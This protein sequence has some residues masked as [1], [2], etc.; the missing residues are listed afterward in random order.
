M[1]EPR[2]LA[3]RRQLDL[4][5]PPVNSLSPIQWQQD[6]I[7][8]NFV[9]QASDPIT[10]ASIVAGSSVSRG[11][12]GFA[13]SQLFPLVRNSQLLQTFLKIGTQGTALTAEA[14]T[15]VISDKSA[16]VA[17]QGA[18]PSTLAWE[19][20]QGLKNSW[21]SAIVNFGSF[22]AVSPFTQGQNAVLR[23]FSNSTAIVGA[24]QITGHWGIT[25]L[26]HEN[27]ISQFV[28][29]SVM[30]LQIQA[31]MH[32]LHGMAPAFAIPSPFHHKLWEKTPVDLS[33]TLF[34]R[35]TASLELLALH[36]QTSGPLDRLS[37]GFIRTRQERNAPDGWTWLR[38]KTAFFFLSAKGKSE[39]ALE[40]T[41]YLARMD[42]SDRNAEF[43]LKAFQLTLGE[44]TGEHTAQIVG[45]AKRAYQNSS[46]P[47]YQARW[48][49]ALNML[50]PRLQGAPRLE[51]VH[52]MLEAALSPY[53]NIADLAENGLL[54]A[55]EKLSREE[56]MTA[57]HHLARLDYQE[58]RAGKRFRS[59]LAA[60][61]MGIHSQ[62][63]PASLPQRIEMADWFGQ[64]IGHWDFNLST[65]AAQNWLELLR[66]LPPAQASS[67]I[68]RHKNN[69]TGNLSAH[70]HGLE[71]SLTQLKR[72]HLWETEKY[73][74]EQRA[75]FSFKALQ[76]TLSHLPL[77]KVWRDLKTRT[78]NLRSPSEVEAWRKDFQDRLRSNDASTKAEVEAWWKQLQPEE[79]WTSLELLI[80][81]K[82]FLELQ[83]NEALHWRKLASMGLPYE[84]GFASPKSRFS[85]S[86]PV[87]MTL[88]RE[89][90]MLPEAYVD[91]IG[92]EAAQNYLFVHHTHPQRRHGNDIN[93][94]YPST[95]SEGGGGGD[96][97]ALYSRF[98]KMSEG[99]QIALSLTHAKGGSIFALRRVNDKA[100]VDIYTGIKA[101]VPHSIQDLS[102]ENVR[103]NIRAWA[104]RNEIELH[105]FEVDYLHV[106]SMDF[107]LGKTKREIL[108]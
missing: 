85:E 29:A 63:E 36:S 39:L 102:L 91:L 53:S 54:N 32:L 31:G 16:R 41:S 3:R 15:F 106:E 78:Q 82:N 20:S 46:D 104:E 1:T 58:Q 96:L 38:F 50:L 26:P 65:H 40:L 56:L 33:T 10:L 21:L 95:F 45:M 107:S 35:I 24:H 98:D 103:R 59:I 70:L 28:H 90:V 74:H 11:I 105:F 49:Y 81:P 2:I 57:G 64:F 87:I 47:A 6:A 5:A 44:L 27:L 88:G 13:Y 18:H 12:Q 73:W 86:D 108:D 25:P 62:S 9:S 93:Q 22:R 80:G 99:E 55:L 8:R 97:H 48:V 37:L 76:N 30:D 7:L 69:F 43:L 14:G 61:S 17:L 72:P 92:L 42:L 79:R 89:S 94:I 84:V 51:A 66:P 68:E 60:L 77:P 34:S 19:G 100:R 71:F 23:N 52:L 67:L 4:T 75:E 83:G 101:D